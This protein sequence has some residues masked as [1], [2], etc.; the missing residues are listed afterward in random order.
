MTVRLKEN[1]KMELEDFVFVF[2]YFWSQF[3]WF[4]GTMLLCYMS[5]LN[6][7]TEYFLLMLPE[8][9]NFEVN[10]RLSVYSDYVRWFCWHN[11]T[12]NVYFLRDHPLQHPDEVYLLIWGQTRNLCDMAVVYFYLD[13]IRKSNSESPEWVQ[14]P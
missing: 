7:I 11:C 12:C 14:V 6:S 10:V 13:E 2:S 8:G 9:E 5:F 4:E 1:R 3:V